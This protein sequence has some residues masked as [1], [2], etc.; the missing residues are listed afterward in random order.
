MLGSF[1]ATPI[2]ID[3]VIYITGF[4]NNAW[5]IDA[6]SGRQIWR[7]RRE[8]PDELVL[9]CG[10]V[11][12]GFAVL[13]DRLF[14]STLDAHLIALDMT[15]GAVIYDVTL[16]DYKHGYSATVAPLVVKDKVILGIAGAEYG[17]RG[18]IEAFDAQTGKKIWR[19]YTVAGPEEFGGNTW[20]KTECLSAW[21]RIDLGDRHLRSRA[22]PRVLRHRQSR[23]RLLQ[24]QSRRRQ[25]LHRRRSSRSMPTPAS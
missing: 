2:V 9:C 15:T 5:A 1:Q 4:N 21:R 13:G 7:Y 25:P 11:N 3:G 18:F 6:R 22:E 16:E 10:P 12:R 19:F 23:S 17:I 20:P 8:L 14:M 24:R